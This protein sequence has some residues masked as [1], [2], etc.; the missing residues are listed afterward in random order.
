MNKTTF[1]H[2]SSDWSEFAA[3]SS[4]G[5]KWTGLF[6]SEIHSLH[7]LSRIRSAALV[8]LHLQWVRFSIVSYSD[9]VT[10]SASSMSLTLELSPAIL[11]YLVLEA[12]QMCEYY[13]VQSFWY[14][15]IL[16]V[17]FQL[18]ASPMWSPS[19]T[20]AV[21]GKD[22]NILLVFISRCTMWE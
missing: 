18:K 13:R 19:V 2:L 12:P 17:E 8:C 14:F 7:S 6:F 15:C 22:E 9:E 16:F 20:P 1:D 10:P 4:F 5:V 11:F 21:C 3:Q